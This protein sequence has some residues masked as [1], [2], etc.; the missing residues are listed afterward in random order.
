MLK[1]IEAPEQVILN[2]ELKRFLRVFYSGF[3]LIV[4]FE[5][6]PFYLKSNFLEADFLWPVYWAKFLPADFVNP[7]AKL[8]FAIGA[9]LLFLVV[10]CPMRRSLRF[11]A[12]LV[13]FEVLAFRYSFGKIDHSDLSWFFC[14]FLLCWC[15]F[16][17]HRS[18]ENQNAKLIHVASGFFLVPYFLSGI[19]KVWGLWSLV[20]RGQSPMDLMVGYL[21]RTL[22]YSSTI[23]GRPFLDLVLPDWLSL[24]SFLLV[25]GFQISCLWPALNF[26]NLRFWG[27]F[28]V[29][30][31]AVTL[32]MMKI[33]FWSSAL[34][35][36]IL[37]VNSPLETKKTATIKS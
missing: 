34:L 19:S 21:P 15:S 24:L 18:N 20:A 14:S 33:N 12:T 6:G 10:Q 27:W 9:F 8:T 23:H 4:L 26:R 29:I 22:N 28:I 37:L 25:V 7:I 36:F 2:E 32:Y 13:L 16:D 1:F 31:H 30:F 17:S 35:A 3:L 5:T 11:I